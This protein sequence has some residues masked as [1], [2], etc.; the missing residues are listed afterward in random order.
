MASTMPSKPDR[1]LHDAR[2]LSEGKLTPCFAAQERGK[3]REIVKEHN[4]SAID[5]ILLTKF[6]SP[7]YLT[8]V[9]RGCVF[10]VLLSLWQTD[11]LINWPEEGSAKR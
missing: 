7:A 8:F 10:H 5:K 1:T 4:K 3:A 2:Q 6:I 11:C 9:D